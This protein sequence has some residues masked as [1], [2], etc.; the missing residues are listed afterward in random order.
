MSEK[1][2][3]PR[4]YLKTPQ[5]FGETP[6]APLR[7]DLHE[8]GD[9]EFTRASA[10]RLQSSLA[11]TALT[12]MRAKHMKMAGLSERSGIKPRQLYRLLHGE[13]WMQIHDIVG[14]SRALNRDLAVGLGY[15]SEDDGV[16]Q[17]SFSTGGQPSPRNSFLD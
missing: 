5:V 14:L 10:A 4:D 7:D 17:I 12:T 11:H 9:P 16:P 15:A 6:D 2:L 13:S 3:K 1:P 8:S